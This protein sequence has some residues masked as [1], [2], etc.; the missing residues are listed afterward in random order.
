MHRLL[1]QKRLGE[2]GERVTSAGSTAAAPAD[3]S[4]RGRGRL[5]WLLAAAVLVVAAFVGWH[6]VAAKA[7]GEIDAGF[8]VPVDCTGTTVTDRRL[9][10]DIGRPVPV[11]APYRGMRCTVRVR[12]VNNSWLPVRIRSVS[13]PILGPE[14][15]SGIQA[16]GAGQRPHEVDAVFTIDRVV[17]SGESMQASYGLRF[18]PGGCDSPGATGWIDTAPDLDVSALGLSGHRDG[19]AVLAWQ[20][21][22]DSSCD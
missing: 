19:D 16:T 18:R 3:G 8:A 1:P 9:S 11:I 21:T 20:G 2:Y 22:P 7:C 15:G 12:V 17:A 5:A 6:L 4:R 10:Q 14:G 13:F